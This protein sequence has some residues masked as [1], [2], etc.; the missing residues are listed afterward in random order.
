MSDATIIDVA[1]I[2]VD[3][4]LEFLKLK[5]PL[6]Q[7]PGLES[8]LKLGKEEWLVVD[9]QQVATGGVKLFLRKVLKS[10]DPGT[11]LFSLPTVADE[12]PEEVPG[13]QAGALRLHEDDWLQ[14]ELL[15]V[16]VVNQASTDL[17]AI[18]AVLASERR[19]PGFEQLHVRKGLAAPFAG[20]PLELRALRERFGTEHP[21]AYLKGK[22]VLKG[23]FAFLLPSGGSLYG[24]ERGGQ[25]VALGL[26][27]RDP[28]P[29]EGLT[30]IDWI[31]AEV[32]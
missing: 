7:V 9:V 8:M 12:I 6:R 10:I 24:Q 20:H 28:C 25:V 3:T 11:I 23:G 26:T 15:P 27:T 14:L 19:G 5:Y 13:E 21:I 4:E 30:L 29:V 32:R 2:D 31:A 16:E 17:Q 18:R 22:G 1:F